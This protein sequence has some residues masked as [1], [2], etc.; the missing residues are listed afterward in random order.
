MKKRLIAAILM[1][2]MLCGCAPTNGGDPVKPDDPTPVD[3]TPAVEYTYYQTDSGLELA[4]IYDFGLLSVEEFTEAKIKSQMRILKNMGFTRVYFVVQNDG[5]P[6]YSSQSNAPTA[7]NY[8][9]KNIQNLG[10]VNTAFA[11][12]CLE[13]GLE[14]YAIFKPYENGGG[15]TLPE[16][17]TV[18][19]VS[20]YD[21]TVGGSHIYFD[22]FTAQNLDKRVQRVDDYDERDF[23]D[24]IDKLEITFV[25]ES[26]TTHSEGKEVSLSSTSLRTPTVNVWV[27]RDNAEYTLYT[28]AFSTDFNREKRILVDA[29]GHALEGGKGLIC[30]VMTVSGLDI[31]PEYKYVA[32]TL[33]DSTSMRTIPYSMIKMFSGDR[34]IAC[35]AT[36]WVRT[37]NAAAGKFDWDWQTDPVLSSSV[38]GV[39]V[40][41]G[42][43]TPKGASGAAIYFYKFGF[44]FNWRGAGSG[45]EGYGIYPIYGIAR[46]KSEYLQGT[47]C[48]AYPEVRQ[49]WL[50]EVNALLEGGFC[51]VDV[52]LSAHSSMMSDY[53]KYG[54]NAP[55]AEQYRKVYGK[56]ISLC[57]DYTEIM[58]VRGDFF[59]QFLEDAAKLIHSK[60][61]SLQIHLF[62]SDESPT[63][64]AYFNK[65]CHWTMPKISLDWKRCVDLV[66]EI[67]L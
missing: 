44:E 32:V 39:I 38:S 28:G 48:E 9:L 4:P 62:S 63:S 15:Y 45:G 31:G 53:E 20:V 1:M 25:L 21:Q 43:P 14:P 36:P 59:M 18:D 55:I 34:E 52:R 22:S 40:K 60:G 30:N 35:T 11:K 27:S 56:D 33:S 41:D 58:K 65:L 8:V 54:Y 51:G 12:V 42:V 29:N 5:A 57:E 67:K 61:A 23:T 46:G 16:G 66:D 19:G 2:L 3:P 7:H 49:F 37:L 50:D 17:I 26:V 10:N 6:M 47:L 64:E 24:T 13:L